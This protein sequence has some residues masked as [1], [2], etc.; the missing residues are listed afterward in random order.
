M[1]LT[2]KKPKHGKL[3]RNNVRLEPHEERTVKFLREQGHDIEL[4]PPRNSPKS[5]TPDLMMLGIAWEMKCPQGKSLKSIDA[6]FLKALKQSTN[7]IID[8]RDTRS[9]EVV[10]IKNLKKR[11]ETTRLCR[12]L[13]II[14][15]TSCELVFKR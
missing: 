15:K 10:A 1:P 5:K 4:I 7:I 12:N 14:T 6:M 11:Y 3:K 13:R 2:R 8:L 9:D